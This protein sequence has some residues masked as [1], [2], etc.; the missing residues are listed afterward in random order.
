M[1]DLVPETIASHWFKYRFELRLLADLKIDRRLCCGTFRSTTKLHVFSD[2]SERAYAAVVYA[3]TTQADKRVM[4][5]LTSSKT[6]VAP[7]K[8]TTLPRL[9]LCAAHLASK[10]VRS[11]LNSWNNLSYPL[12]AW[13]DS[14]ITLTGLRANP[15]L[16]VTFVANGVAEIQEVWPLE[17]WSHVRSEQNP[18]DCA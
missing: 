11:M 14:T 9:E 13:T 2:I 4:V 18:A 12:Y 3:R 7:I 6:K 1:Y 5:S 16:W 8:P 10:L 17:C 15:S